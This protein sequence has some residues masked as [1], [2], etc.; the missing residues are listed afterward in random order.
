MPRRASGFTLL[1]L[2][3]Y[4]GIVAVV[5]TAVTALT[6]DLLR[7]RA[8]ATSL[9]VV[10]QNARLVL[11]RMTTA[12]REA[13]LVNGPPAS[14]FGSSPG[15]LSLAMPEVGRNPTVFDVFANE[16]RITEGSG[17]VA[18]PLTSPDVE[19]AS[20]TFTHLNQATSEGIQINLTVRRKNV[21]GAPEFTVV[22]TYVAG[23]IVR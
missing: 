20:L 13:N 18:T 16:L 3:V 22:Q 14:I 21:S 7:G 17:G 8:K 10:N 12:I 15:R 4:I 5:I 23:T 9:E 11:E 6:I 2:L 19:V 1:E